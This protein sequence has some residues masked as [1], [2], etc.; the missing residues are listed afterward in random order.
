MKTE[1]GVTLIMLGITIVVLIILTSVTI[2]VGLSTYKEFEVQAYVAKMNMIQSR[3]NII[4][5]DIKNGDTSYNNIGQEIG[6]LSPSVQQAVNR[7][8]GETPQTGFKYYDANALKQL[9]LGKIGEDILINFDTR[10]IFS[11]LELEYEG[12][13]YYNQYNLPNGIQLVEYSEISTVDPDFTLTK[14]N[15]GLTARIN[16]TNIVYDSQIN[17]GDIYYAEVTNGTTSPVT[18]DY[19]RQ[20]QGTSFEVNKTAEYAVKII[21]KN[22]GERIKTIKVVTCNSPEMVTGMVPVIYDETNEVWKK[23]EDDNLGQWYDYA[24]KK[25]ANIMLSDGLQV[26]QDGTITSMGSMF[27]WIPRYAYCITSGYQQGGANVRGTIDIKFLKETTNLTTDETTTR[28]SD[29]AGQGNWIIH[30]VFTNG[31]INNYAEGGWD[32][33]LTG[34]WVAKFEASG[35]ENGQAVGNRSASSSTPVAP[36]Q[37]TAV[38]VLPNVI[39]WRDITVGNS[40]Y[41]SMQMCTNTDYGWNTG[42]VDSHLIKNDE[43]GAVA[44]LCYSPYGSVPMTNGCGQSGS[45]GYYDLYTGQGPDSKT[46]EAWYRTKTD[47]RAYDTELGVLSSTTGNVY[48]VYD[49]AGGA[50][51]RVAGFLDNGNSYLGTYGNS[52]YATYFINNSLNSQYA[53]Y[54]NKYQV[55]S[56]EKNN[57]IVTINPETGEEETKTQWQLWNTNLNAETYN[58]AKLRI[59]KATWDNMALCRGIGA[60]EVAGSF[61]YYG[62]NSNGNL[63]WMLTTTQYGYGRAWDNDYMLVGYA[64]YSFQICGGNCDTVSQAGVFALLPTGGSAVHYYGFRPALVVEM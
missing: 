5:Q 9:E 34:F 56:E 37:N 10:E 36:T 38:K 61:S 4:S 41:Y 39:S 3:V 51:E 52:T 22:N 13:V 27:V 48:G 46:S 58:A 54:W 29:R 24:E 35:V 33:E 57:A 43:W 49:M 53:K 1:N 6:S 47:N 40:Q 11:V 63:S 55:S 32:R 42:T 50:W 31:S 62:V 18:V 44:Y 25:W 19:W 14:D 12:N 45:Y 30:P 23:V 26:A 7:A 28:F 15:Y 17:G 8:L 64:L 2:N 16:V 60:N 59:T 20:V 21:D